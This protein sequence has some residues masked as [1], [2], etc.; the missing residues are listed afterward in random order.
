MVAPRSLPCA[1]GLYLRAFI[2]RGS[3]IRDHVIILA[4][5]RNLQRVRDHRISHRPE[6]D[7]DLSSLTVPHSNPILPCF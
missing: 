2:Y 7:D 3:L 4:R 1:Y 5:F 6:Y